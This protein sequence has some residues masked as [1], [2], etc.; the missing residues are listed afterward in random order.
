MEIAYFNGSYLPKDKISVSPDDR[1]FLFGDGIY[2]VMKWYGG[3][4]FD[5]ESHLARLRRSLREIRINWTEADAFPLIAEELIRINKLE[6]KQALVYLQATRG[7]S[8]RNHSFPDPEVQPTTYAFA[9]EIHHSG[10][11]PSPGIRVILRK[12][13]RWSRCDIKSV[14]LLANTLSF[15]EA[16][17]KGMKECIFVREGII[18]EG[19]RS[20]IFL[21]S[22][23]ILYTHPE[24]EFI[25][26]GV[27]R[28]NIIR[29]AKEA[30]IA[31]REMPFPEKELVTVQEAFITNSSAEVTPVTAFETV[32]VGSGT[33][34][35]VTLQIHKKFQAELAYLNG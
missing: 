25:L 21:V 27:T 13:I 31:V 15:Q 14:S 4:F 3:F 30:G 17:E 20:N 23:G 10:S 6:E 12:D 24:S 5:Q 34:G 28:K 11:E 16:H 32:Q 9:R 22:D 29:L 18:T 8:P 35:P 1:G 7:V 26:S 33:T 19:S 2:E